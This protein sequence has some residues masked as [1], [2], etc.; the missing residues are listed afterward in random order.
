MFALLLMLSLSAFGPCRWSETTVL[1][2]FPPMSY[3]QISA[4]RDEQGLYI[5]TYVYKYR[6]DGT[7][8]PAILLRSIPADP[9]FE[10][11]ILL[12][13]YEDDTHI[14]FIK[15]GRSLHLIWGTTHAT[16]DSNDS[17]LLTSLQLSRFEDGAWSQPEII[18][19]EPKGISWDPNLMGDPSIDRNGTLHLLFPLSLGTGL[20]YLRNEGGSWIRG[21]AP[22]NSASYVDL[23]ASSPDTLYAVLIGSNLELQYSSPGT[24]ST[25][26]ILFVASYD[27][28]NTWS[29][30]TLVTSGD[31]LSSLPDL[32]V[33]DSGIIYLAWGQN[34]SG[35]PLPE[36]ILVSSSQD[37]GATWTGPEKIVYG[38]GVLRDVDII[39]TCG[40]LSL[41]FE[42]FRTP[43]DFGVY[44]AH[45]ETRGWSEP[46]LVAYGTGYGLTARQG[47]NGDL[48]L[49]TMQNEEDVRSHEPNRSVLPKTVVRV[50][51]M[52]DK[53]IESP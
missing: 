43:D 12:P 5:A 9:S 2:S 11:E 34:L 29:P 21:Q 39:E 17:L 15:V 52:I 18:F 32:M 51:Q 36:S 26:S 16:P 53:A 7:R 19:E 50:F 3:G 30:A 33:S 8:V 48:L 23:W 31:R 25:N 22:A 27:G 24:L 40:G 35:G 14:E 4:A 37:G 46:K 44:H 45:R 47:A 42:V 6:P 10:S 38:A 28:G 49:Q 1:E 13:D 41:V 20:V